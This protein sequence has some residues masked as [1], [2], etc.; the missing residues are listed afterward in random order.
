MNIQIVARTNNVTGSEKAYAEEKLTKL[1]RYFDHI[2]SMEVLLERDG[3]RSQVEVILAA[4]RNQT[5]VGKET[6]ADLAAAIDLVADKLERQIKKYKE[7]KRSHRVKK[8]AAGPAPAEK[9]P[10]ETYEDVIDKEF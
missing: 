10:E 2:H 8:P 6:Q 7:R 4:G 3:E 5:F 9:E 1:T